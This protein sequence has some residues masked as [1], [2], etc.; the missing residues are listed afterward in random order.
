MSWDIVLGIGQQ[1]LIGVIRF[2]RVC[3]KRCGCLG[4]LALLLVFFLMVVH[5]Y[6]CTQ[7]KNYMDII[8]VIHSTKFWNCIHKIK[9]CIIN[10]RR[11]N[12]TSPK[13]NN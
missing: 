5:V 9:Q 11:G 12:I 4:I 10:I 13:R 2:C 3:F 8:Y 1:M 7:K 6:Y